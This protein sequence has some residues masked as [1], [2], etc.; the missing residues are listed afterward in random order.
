[1]KIVKLLYLKYFLSISICLISSFIIFFIFSLLG[2][3]NE[4]YLFDKII[5]LSLLNSLQILT[6]IPS[7]IFLM[8]VI[9]FTIFLK[10][11]NE[12][13]IIK[14]YLNIRRLFIFFLPIILLFTIIELNKKN[15]V[16][17]LEDSKAKLLNQNNKVMPKILIEDFENTK[18]YTVFN[19][20]NSENTDDTEYRSYIILDKKIIL[21]HF[22][23]SLIFINNNLIANKFTQY[24]N[25]LIEDFEIP[26]LI[27][28][29]YIDLIQQSSIVKDIS[30]KNN[31]EFNVEYINIIFFFIMFFCYI[32][33]I[34]SSK[35]FINSKKS[36]V[37]PILF[38][39]IA[40]LYSLFIFNNS[41][42][43]YKREFEVLA[44]VIITMMVL[45][46][47]LNE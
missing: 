39:M 7:F 37:Y 25:N 18:T 23:N 24:K 36:L 40:L 11:K 35:K 31:L 33:L 8:T 1:M 9:L 6:Y 10:S 29:E 16:V 14:S 43:F 41:L 5:N 4:D 45:R 38:C 15:M 42:S 46:Q 44:S 17:F 21:A 27:D 2:N 47:G 13:I 19:K 32:F 3:L 28:I 20:I 30:L 34:F 26:K 22:S 12:I